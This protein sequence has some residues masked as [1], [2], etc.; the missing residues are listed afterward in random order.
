MKV[1]IIFSDGTLETIPLEYTTGNTLEEFQGH[2]TEDVLEAI[3]VGELTPEDI[4]AVV[5]DNLR[6]YI[7]QGMK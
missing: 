2:D 3:E 5:A 6:A 1:A 4:A 7:A